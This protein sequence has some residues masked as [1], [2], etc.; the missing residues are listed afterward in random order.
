MQK[1]HG[2]AES[3]D[4]FDVKK[5]ED[6]FNTYE[7]GL[8]CRCLPN[9]TRVS[10]TDKC[11]GDKL[12]NERLTVLVTANMVEEKLPPLFIGKSANPRCFKSIKK[13]PLTYKSNKKAWITAT[14]FKGWVKKLDSRMRKSNRTVA[15]E[16]QNSRTVALDNCT[17]HP[18]VIGLTNFK[19]I[20][21]PPN[22][23]AKT[24][25]MDVGRK[26]TSRSTF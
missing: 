22:T 16:Q 2:E 4:Q 25:P 1:L 11:T 14:I 10:K 5:V 20:V 21:L 18:N 19:L 9:R 6:I 17:A 12:S 13:L 24:Q 15:L 8:F 3:V 7:T 23:T 26:R